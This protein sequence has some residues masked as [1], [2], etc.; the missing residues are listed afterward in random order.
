MKKR[1]LGRS[2]VVIALLVLCISARAQSGDAE[3]AQKLTNPVADLISVP[4][5][6]N[7]DRDIGPVDEGTKTTINVQPVIP[8]RLNEDWNL[9]TRTIVPIIKQEDIY[10]G[11]GSQSGL[12]DIN[13]SLF[14]SPRSPSASGLIWG[15]GPVLLLPTGTDDL[16]TADKW[17]AGPSAVVLALRGRWTTGVLANHIWSFAG[18]SSRQDISNTFLQ[19]FAS[20]TWPS[21]WTVSVTSESSYNWK[22]E[23]WSVP[24][25]V[26]VAK[27]LRI[28][29]L[30]VSLMGGVGY[31]VES[32]PNGPEGVR[33]RLQ[34]AFILPK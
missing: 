1:S 29:K 32:A 17:G 34:A 7:V 3:L 4:I 23:Q 5:Q 31:W 11:A 20:H 21:A 30:P 15:V 12:G 19:P 10:P 26:S 33:F 24:V 9:I 13:V 2:G 27:L 18:E 22:D 25:N 6:M 14:F 28:G 16:L 8:F